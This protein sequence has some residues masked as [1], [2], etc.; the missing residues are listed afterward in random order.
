MHIISRYTTCASKH[1][2]SRRFTCTYICTCALTYTY[3]YIHRLVT[4]RA[5]SGVV[6]ARTHAL[7]G[8]SIPATRAQHTPTHTSRYAKLSQSS[9]RHI[10]TQTSI[11]TAHLI[12]IYAC[13]SY[14]LDGFGE[15]LED[16]PLGEDLVR[17][18]LHV[19]ILMSS[20]RHGVPVPLGRLQVR[21]IVGRVLDAE[22]RRA[23]PLD[24]ADL[25]LDD[26]CDDE[27]MIVVR[28]SCCCRLLLLLLLLLRRRTVQ[29]I[30]APRRYH[31]L[32]AHQPHRSRLWRAA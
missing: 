22:R 31:V 19:R 25:L 1:D 28:L 17:A 27:P 21:D 4:A 32:L 5:D 18:E 26:C 15:L 2:C 12:L 14:Q 6:L 13:V 20:R 8:K 23:L 24:E 3:T 9:A 11:R 7:R 10:H 30:A 16:P 29:A